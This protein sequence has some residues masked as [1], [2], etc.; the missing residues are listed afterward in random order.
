MGRRPD[1]ALEMEVLGVLWHADGPMTPGEVRDELPDDLAYTTVMTVLSRLFDKQVVSR[2][3]R[4]R[5]Y[6]YE[7][8]VAE[9]EFT[10][11]RMDEVLARASDR[12]GALSGFV[13]NLSKRDVEILRRAMSDDAP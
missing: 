8:A 6:Q 7:P 4:G 9:S 10:A 3:E 12:A 5:G 1:G 2:S 13:G 11:R